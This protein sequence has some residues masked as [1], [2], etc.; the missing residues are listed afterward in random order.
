MKHVRI[1]ARSGKKGKSYLVLGPCPKT[2]K[3]I[4]YGTFDRKHDAEAKAADVRDGL[5]NQTEFG[6]RETRTVR[7]LVL[8]FMKECD[9]R[10]KWTI[11]HKAWHERGRSLAPHTHR[12][13]REAAKDI[14]PHIGDIVLL[15]LELADLQ[16]MVD[17]IVSDVTSSVGRRA[18]ET[19]KTILRWGAL[20]DWTIKPRLLGLLGRLRLPPKSK[21]EV[22]GT[23]EHYRAIF[24]VIFGPRRHKLTRMGYLI[25]RVLWTVFLSNGPRRSEIAEIRIEDIDW[26]T[27][28]VRVKGSRCTLTGIE[29]A[30][31]SKAGI[32]PLWFPKQALDASEWIL[33]LRDNPTE[34]K[35]FEPQVGE[36]IA[37][38]M[39]A[40]HLLPVLEAAGIPRSVSKGVINFHSTR[41]RSTSEHKD[42]GVSKPARQLLLGH[43]R[44]R[45]VTDGYTH[46][47]PERQMLTEHVEARDAAQAIVDEYMPQEVTPIEEAIKLKETAYRRWDPEKRRVYHREYMKRYR[48][49]GR[50]L[51]PGLADNPESRRQKR[52]EQRATADTADQWETDK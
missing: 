29:K 47:L 33:K 35:L 7:D 42:R 25:E 43:S 27:G 38:G 14:L 10:L 19:M 49:E 36:T 34:G 15:A 3:E 17:D 45:D 39:Y 51:R 18:G 32:R 24:K 8:A 9:D 26:V 2:G 28:R 20:Y 52:R 31:K 48:A 13:Y 4:A 50:H 6:K 12:G 23:D 16:K 30:T 1:R 21:R 46:D 37:R 11:E 44:G 5:Y 40:S 22:I 41:H